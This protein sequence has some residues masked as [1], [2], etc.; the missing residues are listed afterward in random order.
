MKARVLS[1]EE[2]KKMCNEF[3]ELCSLGAEDEI[4]H[5]GEDVEVRFINEDGS[6]GY[7]SIYDLF[8]YHDQMYYWTQRKTLKE[9][10][11]LDDFDLYGSLGNLHMFEP[12]NIF[13]VMFAGFYTGYRDDKGKKIYTGDVVK[14]T[15]IMNT[16]IISNGEKSR[17]RHPNKNYKGYTFIAG[18]NNFGEGNDDYYYV[19]D[20]CP[21]QMRYTNKVV[22]IGNVF[23]DLDYDNMDAKIGER[24]AMLAFPYNINVRNLHIKMAHAPYFKCKTWQD[25][26]LKVL[27]GE[28]RYDDL[29][30]FINNKDK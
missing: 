9:H 12:I 26:A 2:L 22:I 16:N 6:F 28:P 21:I 25:I 19:L 1:L 7:T 11:T 3:L 17:A 23:Y 30:I 18:V 15:A 5:Y 27:K 20:N 8:F 24:C 14:A 13:P 29:P 4:E 10:L